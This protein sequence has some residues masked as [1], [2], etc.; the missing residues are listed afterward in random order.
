[1]DAKSWRAPDVVNLPWAVGHR[2]DMP[3]AYF[4]QTQRAPRIFPE[5]RRDFFT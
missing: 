5:L 2:W 3:V 4:I 1:M